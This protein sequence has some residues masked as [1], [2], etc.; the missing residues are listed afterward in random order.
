[1]KIFGKKLN[2]VH[3]RIKRLRMDA[4]LPL[5]GTDA[6]NLTATNVE[7]DQEHDMYVYH[8]NL[9][10]EV[11]DGYRILFFPSPSN[12]KVDA[13]ICNYTYSNGELI[14]CYK[15]RDSLRTIALE[16]RYVNFIESLEFKDIDRLTLEE[17]KNISSVSWLDTMRNPLSFAP[18]NAREIIAQMV[19][20]PKLIVNIEE[21][22]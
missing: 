18:Y 14:I 10:L 17:A 3:V 15:N 4:R 6:I 8:T 20:V 22:R 11:D 12:N 21:V 7:Y 9:S 19:V 13:Y 1:M 2:D 5:Y 16:S